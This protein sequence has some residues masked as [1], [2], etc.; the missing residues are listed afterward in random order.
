MEVVKYQTKCLYGA[1]GLWT[2][3]KYLNSKYQKF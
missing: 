1:T 2:T 3:P